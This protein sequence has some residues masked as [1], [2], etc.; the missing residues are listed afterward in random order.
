MQKVLLSLCCAALL[1]LALVGP[2]AAGSSAPAAAGNDPALA[3]IFAADIGIEE[4]LD[5]AFILECGP[6]GAF[7]DDCSSLCPTGYTGVCRRTRGCYT[8]DGYLYDWFCA[9]SN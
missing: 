1:G 6:C 4:P 3:A 5:L 7:G 2:A 9:C 8:Q